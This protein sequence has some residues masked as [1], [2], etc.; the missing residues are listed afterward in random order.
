M[1]ERAT[2]SAAGRILLVGGRD[3]SADLDA[4]LSKDGFRTGWSSDLKTLASTVGQ[5]RPE[6]VV[7]TAGLPGRDSEKLLEALRADARLKGIPFLADAAVEVKGLDVDDV[8]H[9]REE[10]TRR[11]T[12]ALQARR[13][14]ER[15][16]AARRRMEAL[17]EITQAATSSLELDQILTIAVEKLGKVLSAARCSVI[18]VEG[19]TSRAA[20][21][22]ASRN[23]DNV[24]PLH[25][26]LARYPELRQALET[27]T[28]V[29]VEDAARDPRMEEVRRYILPLGV[30]SILVQPLISQD[31]LMG[32]LFFRVSRD[33]AG[34]TKEDQELAQAVAGALAN[35][36]RNARLHQA[37][38]R[39]R[40]DLESAY[41]DRYRELTEANKRLKE[42]NRVKDEVIAVCSH[43]LRSPLNVLLGHG[44]LLLDEDLE[45]RQRSSLEAMNRQGRKIL[46]LVESL[47]EKGRGE[48]VRVSLDAKPVDLSELCKEA[49]SEL[50]IIAAGHKVSLRS[51]TPE[52]LVVI[53][54]AVKLREILHNLVTNAIQ[55]TPE[56]GSVVV[57][58]QRQRRPD[59]DAARVVVEDTGPGI[60]SDQLHLVFDKY[61]HGPGGTGLGLAIC[62]EFVDL[63]GGEIWAEAPA[64]GGASF[65]FT[66]PLIS[67]K[68]LDSSKATSRLLAE[69]GELPRALV[70]EDEPETASMAAEILRTR[71]RVDVARDGAE[72]LAKARASLP[73]VIVLDVFLPK[74]DGLDVLAALKASVDTENTPVIL[75]SAHQGVADK[76]RAMGLGALDYLA[77]PFQPL[78]LLRCA[79]RAV[80]LRD[81]QRE[82]TR[83][84]SLLR[85]A[86]SDPE[87]GLSD[88][89][90]FLTRLTQESARA[91]RYGRPL[92]LALLVPAASVHQSLRVCAALVRSRM[93]LT[94][95]VGHLGDG[96]FALLLPESEAEGARISLSRLVA[97]LHEAAGVEYRAV[98]ENLPDEEINPEN[99]LEGLKARL[100]A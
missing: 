80:D 16:E 97:A 10:L 89:H 86:G 54:D 4:L 2:S 30:R 27:R 19:Q 47:L 93:R 77:K 69:P 66:I 57:R 75:L 40:E 96:T 20:R 73:D 87:S 38:K 15:D 9:V 41:V 84:Q 12:A 34:F 11:L 17:L 48:Q 68:P 36:V 72:G 50:N 37:L 56:G 21:V 39:K 60:P 18:L 52:S 61:R 78:E 59:G 46:E 99:L 43:D 83:S 64:K 25:I 81:A 92:S 55:H 32:A 95:V 23:T 44:K 42:L 88:R 71:F 79:E 8:V 1:I 14:L 33:E 31:D 94:D 85:Q 7:F 62:R 5:L 70:V 28:T 13:M 74:L 58:C 22:V 53:G 90:G 45:P 65:I 100:G 6:A 24:V 49:A 26:D 3:A 76:V 35:S 29:L 91:R 51:E 67:E 98:I 63:H 82:L